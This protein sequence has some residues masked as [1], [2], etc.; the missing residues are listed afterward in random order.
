MNVIPL[1]TDVSV[2]SPYNFTIRD[3]IPGVPYVVLMIAVNNIG[4]SIFS[5]IIEFTLPTVPGAPTIDSITP[6]NS[7]ATVAF[8]APLDD[9]G[10]PI[11]G[12]QYSCYETIDGSGPFLDVSGNPFTISGL[13]NG[14][15]YTVLLVAVNS[16]GTSSASS[17]TLTPATVPSAPIVD[18]LIPGNNTIT[19]LFTPQSDGGSPITSYK[20]SS[21]PISLS[22]ITISP[23]PSNQFVIS[24]LTPFADP[25]YRIIMRAINNVGESE[26]SNSVY[27]NP[28]GVDPLD[29]LLL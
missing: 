12:Y 1:F 13:I 15:E 18:T 17:S 28:N 9:G 10:S 24:G 8:T 20:Y 11:T 21:S 23:P 7:T 5:N 3:L 26:N 25:G 16:A 6:G 29:P 27:G 22:F 4:D 14:A 19:V 2:N